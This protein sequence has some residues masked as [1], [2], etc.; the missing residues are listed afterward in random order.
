MRQMRFQ[1][2]LQP[3]IHRIFYG[4]V[5]IALMAAIQPHFSG[6]L[7]QR[8]SL[9]FLDFF[10]FFATLA[11][12]NLDR[13]VEVLWERPQNERLRWLQANQREWGVFTLLPL[14]FGTYFFT[15][16]S[17]MA[18]IVLLLAG[19]LALLYSLPVRL[20][21]AP[22]RIS[23]LKP[24][25]VTGVW[26][27]LG[28]G[29]VALENSATAAFDFPLIL[30]YGLWVLCLSLTFEWRDRHKDQL[31]LVANVWQRRSLQHIQSALIVLHALS[32]LL[33]LF[34]SNLNFL[35]IVIA[36]LTSLFICGWAIRTKHEMAYLLGVDGLLLLVPLLLWLG[37][38]IR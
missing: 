32:I 36:L 19:V 6:L 7:L 24:V 2:H 17:P 25:L 38:A 18:Q 10:L 21:F 12:Y 9:P 22:K 15:L 28:P 4:N 29:L 1:G 31:S 35:F 34:F 27:L 8:D 13:W 20:R 3:L 5:W 37:E 11:Y 14:V 26:T 30:A 23:W 16:L 33:L